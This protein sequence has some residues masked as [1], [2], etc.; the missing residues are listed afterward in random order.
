MQ[1]R[2]LRDLEVS[3]LGLGC[4][5]MSAFYG[6]ADEDEAIATIQRALELGCTFFDTAE[7]Y[8]P[9]TN[10]ELLGGAPSRARCSGS[11]RTTWTCTT[12]TASTLRR[13]SRTRWVPWPRWSRRARCATSG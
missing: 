12:S 3:A 8:G 13:R 6:A 5:G 4:M 2:K 9:Y 7:M 1:T 11:A 10:E